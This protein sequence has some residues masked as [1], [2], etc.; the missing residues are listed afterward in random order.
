[1]ERQGDERGCK[2][3]RGASGRQRLSGLDRHR[4]ER[5][6]QLSGDRGVGTETAESE[7]PG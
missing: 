7:A 3:R 6:E 5:T 1:M 2:C 4:F